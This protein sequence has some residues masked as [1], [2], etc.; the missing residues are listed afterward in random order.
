MRTALAGAEMHV[1]CRA[2]ATRER[3]T[4]SDVE[5][6][7]RAA[8]CAL[9]T[10]RMTYTQR[11]LDLAVRHV[12]TFERFIEDHKRML[13]ESTWEPAL[14]AS[15]E[16]LLSRLEQALDES[17]RRCEAIRLALDEGGAPEGG[18]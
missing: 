11:D 18:G 12:R 1:V 3:G 9:M 17:R 10:T 5:R 6:A 7:R 13:S 2:H 16:V 15:A 14:R 8:D 4:F